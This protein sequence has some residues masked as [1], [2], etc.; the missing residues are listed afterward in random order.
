[1]NN[2][3]TQQFYV[4]EFILVIGMYI[5]VMNICSQIKYIY[6]NKL[7]CYEILNNYSMCN[8]SFSLFL[9]IYAHTRVCVYVYT[10]F[11]FESNYRFIGKL[12]KM[13]G[14][15]TYSLPQCLQGLSHYQHPEWY[16]CYNRY[17]LTHCYHLKFIF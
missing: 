15:P 1:M 17:T 14:V 13:Y 6:L 7:T 5:T 3:L 10:D 9:C 2:F 8:L 4:W 11:T 12:S 16:I